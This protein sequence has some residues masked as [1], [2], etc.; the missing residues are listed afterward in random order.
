M[1]F[2]YSLVTWKYNTGENNAMYAKN[3]KI[4]E[5]YLGILL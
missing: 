1:Y 5:N 3:G 2:L 4:P